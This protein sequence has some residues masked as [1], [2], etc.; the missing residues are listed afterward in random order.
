MSIFTKNIIRKHQSASY[1]NFRYRLV[2]YALKYVEGI[3]YKYR[4]PSCKMDAVD[5]ID[6][7]TMF[8]LRPLH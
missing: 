1:I 8:R 4:R 7:L 3:Y 5:E 2:D 6:F